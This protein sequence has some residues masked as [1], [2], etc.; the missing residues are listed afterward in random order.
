MVVTMVP[1]TM[2]T[3]II[4]PAHFCPRWES[5]RRDTEVDLLIRLGV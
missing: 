1:A 5:V 3:A 4:P 2:A